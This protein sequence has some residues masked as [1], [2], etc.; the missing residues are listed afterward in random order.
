VSGKDGFCPHV[1]AYEPYAS[2]VT[3]KSKIHRWMASAEFKYYILG[4]F[5]SGFSNHGPA[6][7]VKDGFCPHVNA[8]EPYA[9]HVTLQ[10]K[11]HLWMASA[12]FK[13]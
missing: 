5:E 6:V 4:Y 7:S 3:L 8:H 10:L 11:I 12:E 9:S 1:D 13:Y 2:Y